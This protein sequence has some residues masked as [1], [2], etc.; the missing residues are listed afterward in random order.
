MVLSLKSEKVS[1]ERKPMLNFNAKTSKSS[2]LFEKKIKTMSEVL[3]TA[4]VLPRNWMQ[5]EQR[6]MP[7]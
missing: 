6:V 5:I 4:M 2:I 3:N 1:L 7:S